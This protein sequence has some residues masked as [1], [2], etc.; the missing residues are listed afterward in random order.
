MR[1]R[2]CLSLLALCVTSALPAQQHGATPPN[3]N[4]ARRP[5]QPDPFRFQMLGPAEGGRIAAITG[6]PGD[7]RVWYVGA[8][9]GGVW[10]SIDSG[11]TFR[12]VFDSMRVQAIGALAVAPSRPAT[13]WAGTGEAWAIRDADLIGDGVYKST[14]SGTT[15][16]NMG[17]RET[18]RIQRILVHPT[19]PNIVFVC[20]LGRATGPQH[21][22]G[23]FRTTDGGKT[24]TQVLFVDENTGCSGLT[25]DAKNPKVLFAGTWQVVMHTW[26]MFSGGPGSGIYV[27]RDGGSTWTRIQHPGLPKSPVGK[28]DVAVAPT[29][30]NRVYALIQTADQGSVWRSDDGGRAWKVVNYQRALIGRAGYYIHLAVS[31]GSADEILVANSSFFQSKD[32][33]KSFAEVPWG[34]DNHDIWIDPKNPNHFGLTN[35][36]GAR[37]TH[38]HGKSFQSIAL[39]IAQMY[40]VAVDNQVPYWVYGNRQDNGTMRGPSTAPEA[41]TATRGIAAGAGRGRGGGGRAG[42]G[43]ADTAAGRGR[44][45]GRGPGVR[46]DTSAAR[47]AARGGTDAGRTGTRPDSANADSTAGGRG[48]GGFGGSST[49]DHGLGGCESGFTLPDPTDPNIVWASCYGDAVTRYDHRVKRARSVSPWIHTLDSPPDKLKYR[50]HWTPPLAIDPF[51]HNTVYYGCQVVFKTSNGG[52]SWSVISPDLSTRDPSRIVS[53]GGI[54]EDNLGQFYGELVFAIAPSDA[55]RGLIWAG[56]NDGKVWYTKDGGGTWTDATNGLTAA[57]LPTWGTVRKIEPSHFDPATAYVA[58][59]FHMMDNRKPYIFKTTDFGAT[60]RN[61]TGDLPS[62]HPLDYVMAVTENPN[63][64]GMLFAG[65]GR[66]FYYS[67]DDGAHWTEFDEGL[68]HTAVSWIVVPKQWHDVVVST[69]GRGIFVLR[70][71]A[72]LELKGQ[73]ADADVTL[74]PPHPGYRQARS[75][76]ADITFALKAASPRPA[77]VEILD[78]AGAVMRTLQVP[79][80]VGY[81]RAVWDVRYDP[82]H[83]VALRTA[84][85][86]NPHIFEEPRFHNRTTR[87]VTH[88]GIQG[89]QVSGPIAVPGTYSVRLLVNGKTKTQPLTI[90]RDPDIAT[91]EADLVASTATQIR[92]RNAMTAS[93]DLVNRL[94]IMRKQIADQVKAN[95]EKPDIERALSDLDKKMMDVE[96]RLLSRSDMNSDD[97]YYVEPYRIYMSLIWLNGEV[98]SGAGDVAGGAD[99]PPTDASL[100]WLA[101]LEK[102]LAAAKDA[103][104]SL[105][106]TD[107]AAFNQSMDGKLPAIVE[108]LR[109]V[110]P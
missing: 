102:Q 48:G 77:R 22:R 83:T 100:A 6:V 105:V 39:P 27:S 93:A 2:S 36:L 90:L 86:D 95:A 80:R 91:S 108:T 40:H 31:S 62:A 70:D 44:A 9:S 5:P 109:A 59:D 47:L 63:R 54:V 110:Q 85:P 78:S 38:D 50:C 107:V 33:G 92:V 24:W 1:L 12:P 106:E 43:G 55:Q 13:V 20:A 79:T 35:D 82:P 97:K 57:G 11:A 14:D 18:G 103:Y 76:R 53:S 46:G 73:V 66:G 98:N 65:T 21:E 41:T 101:D 51:D 42:R 64:R 74:Y 88:W 56:T 17:L 8:A 30:S 87:P 104:K 67:L 89:A 99:A 52:Q 81:N 10:K 68:P 32:G 4:P 34:G 23:V 72:P 16:T 94:E 15:W 71:I 69:Y 7:L 60:W 37:I 3:Q 49:W 29:N 96:L 58:V 45:G 25:I 26:A 19:N 61:V 75:G 84:A 28:I